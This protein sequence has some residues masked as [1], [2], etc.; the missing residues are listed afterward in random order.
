MRYNVL[1][2]TA[3]VLSLVSLGSCSRGK[4]NGAAEDISATS[5]TSE[6]TKEIGQGE[7]MPSAA[8]HKPT[9][10]PAPV[11]NSTA[12]A[13][14]AGSTV[15]HVPPYIPG[16]PQ[17]YIPLWQCILPALRPPVSNPDDFKTIKPNSSQLAKSLLGMVFDRQPPCVKN[18]LDGGADVNATLTSPDEFADGPALTL[19]LNQ[20]NWSMA[21]Y[22]L[23][24]G[25]DPNVRTPR[26]GC[27]ALDMAYGSYATEGVI[28]ALKQ[29]GAKQAN[30]GL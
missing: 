30:C 26:H 4:S 18:L 10:L 22:L 11:P 5:T 25:A 16:G 23:S 29:H 20:R 9:D 8:P 24:R 15:V 7:P 28:A 12:P 1:L 19:A 13:A 6:A 17:G 2:V 21:E 27:T 14:P 3:L